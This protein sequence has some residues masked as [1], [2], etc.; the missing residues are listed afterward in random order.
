[1]YVAT[2]DTDGS[3]AFRD[4]A[5]KHIIEPGASI[6]ITG[7]QHRAAA[8]TA[9]LD[10]DRTTTPPTRPS[11]VASANVASAAASSVPRS[12]KRRAQVTVHD[13]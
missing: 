3:I 5:G 1:M 4:D 6:I 10:V 8:V 13:A 9:G 11:V 2:N 7:D 12:R